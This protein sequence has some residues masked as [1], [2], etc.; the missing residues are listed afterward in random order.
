MKYLPFIIFFSI[1]FGLFLSG[2]WYVFHRGMQALPPGT[3]RSIFPWLFWIISS[4]FIV[5]QFLERTE[6]TMATRVI[7]TIGSF[8]LV[9]LWY[10]FMFVVVI[11]I[12]RLGNHFLGFIPDTW[13]Q[14]F[15]TGKNLFI[16]TSVVTLLLVLAGH[17]NAIYPRI[18]QVDI[19]LEKIKT[20]EQELKVALATDIHMGFII[21]NHRVKRLVNKINEQNPDV[22]LFGGDLVDHNP[23]PVIK[24]K[25]GEHFTRLHAPLGVYAITGNHEYIGHPEVSIN[26]LSKF[27]INYLRDTALNINNQLLLVGRED[28]DKTR[29]T[30]QKRKP[31]TLLLE[32]TSTHLP[33]LLLDHQPVELGKA[34]EAGVD[35]MMSGHTHRG[36]FWPFSYITRKVYELDWGYL[37]KGNTHYYVSSGYGTWGPPVRIGSRSEIVILN[38]KMKLP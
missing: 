4:F 33:V 3:F 37:Q 32:D 5:G 28:K 25:M 1:F 24:W 10:L 8:W 20:P 9:T 21:G 15:L 18:V 29:F 36:Q 11:D 7:S 14:S 13:T 30:G 2:S 27:G 34:A 19:P 35:V 22:V 38:L 23:L 16:G 17:L 6:P 26:Y 31:L 12:F